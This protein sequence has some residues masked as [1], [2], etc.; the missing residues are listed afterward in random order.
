VR[1]NAEAGQWQP[2]KEQQFALA[3]ATKKA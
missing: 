1:A 2:T 3:V